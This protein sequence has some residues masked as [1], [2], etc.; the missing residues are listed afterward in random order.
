MSSPARTLAVFEAFEQ[1][2]QQLQ[3]RELAIRCGMPLSTVHSIVRDLLAR[4]Y[5]YSFGRTKALYPTRRLLNMAQTFAAHDPYIRR[6]Q[7]ALESVRDDTGETVILAKRQEDAVL[8]LQVVE[9][10]RS[11]RYSPKAGDLRELHATAVGRAL[12]SN[13]ADEQVAQWLKNRALSRITPATLTDPEEIA[14][15]VHRSRERGY[16]I[17]RGENQ[18]GLTAV[19]VSASLEGEDLGIVVAGPAE[20]MEPSIASTADRLLRLKQELVGHR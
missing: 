8:Y 7:S 16:F 12:L 19:A 1:A 20:R 4:G 15:E 9:G 18:E 13:L 10:P 17:A 14:A 3:L 5:L 6:L 11:I 2:K